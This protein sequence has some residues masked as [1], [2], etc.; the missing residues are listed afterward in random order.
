MA[1]THLTTAE[2][3]TIK[4]ATDPNAVDTAV[5]NL[6][7][8]RTGAGATDQFRADFRATAAGTAQNNDRNLV[9]QMV[10][11]EVADQTGATTA[12]NNTNLVNP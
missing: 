6:M 4:A 8:A 5:T 9:G 3:A 10:D 1:P 2:R 12:T 11:A 7:T